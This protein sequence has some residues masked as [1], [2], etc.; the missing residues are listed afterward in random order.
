[1]PNFMLHKD[2]LTTDYYNL[3]GNSCDYYIPD[4]Y[5]DL[6]IRHSQL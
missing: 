5:D 2:T 3:G 1:M 4:E 6:A